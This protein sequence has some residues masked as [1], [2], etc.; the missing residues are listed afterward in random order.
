MGGH[1]HNLANS[2]RHTWSHMCSPVYEALKAAC[3]VKEHC[4]H[5]LMFILDTTVTEKNKGC[6]RLS[7]SVTMHLASCSRF[8]A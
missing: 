4:E 5:S 1:E 6:L 3:E 2:A 8:Y 7:F